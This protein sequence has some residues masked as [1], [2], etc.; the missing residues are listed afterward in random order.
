MKR[1]AVRWP[2]LRRRLPSAC[3]PEAADERAAYHPYR[4]HH[5]LTLAELAAGLAAAGFRL[6]G[7]KRFLWVPKT[8]PAALLPAGRALEAA[9]EGLPVVRRLGA[10]TLVW[11][12][13]A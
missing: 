12:T 11:A 9:A 6:E 13:R 3:F 4:Y 2:A 5:P 10:T 8:L 7:A 1:A